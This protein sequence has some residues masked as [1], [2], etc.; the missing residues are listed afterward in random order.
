MI[1][2]SSVKGDIQ[3]NQQAFNEMGELREAVKKYEWAGE[4]LKAA[5]IHQLYI[6]LY[7]RSNG[8]PVG[9]YWKL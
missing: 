4:F 2:L 1:I 5:L 7:L 8:L 6:E 3:M 9:E